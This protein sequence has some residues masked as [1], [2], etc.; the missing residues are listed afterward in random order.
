M[1]VAWA[2]SVYFVHFPEESMKYLK[3]N[4][5]DNWTYNKAIQ[6]ITESYRVEK[7]MKELLRRMKRKI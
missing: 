2:V 7:E 5:L 3:N 6:K 1:A 4:Q